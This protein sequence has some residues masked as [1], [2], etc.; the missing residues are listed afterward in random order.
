MA[1]VVHK[2]AFGTS[3][4]ETVPAGA[5][6]VQIEVYGAGG[7]GGASA[8]NSA[9]GGGGGGYTTKT[10]G[11]T[12][13]DTLTYTIGFG[14]GGETAPNNGAVGTTVTVTGTVSG[15]SVSLTANSG[16]GGFSSGAG[17]SG[18]T[19]S[20]GTTNN[21]GGSG[22]AAGAGGTGA[23]PLA[24][25]G[26]VAGPAGNVGTVPGGGGGGSGVGSSGAGASGE[27]IFTYSTIFADFM[28]ESFQT[29]VENTTFLRKSVQFL[30]ATF[31]ILSAPQPAGVVINPPIASVAMA[32]IVP[33]TQNT[34]NPMSWT[35]A[36][37]YVQTDAPVRNNWIARSWM[38][39]AQSNIGTVINVP[40]T[41]V[42]LHANTAGTYS[43]SMWVW[44][45]S[46]DGW[47]P[48]EVITWKANASYNFDLLAAPN[49]VASGGAVTIS[50]PFGS[51]ATGT[52]QPIINTG[53]PSFVIPVAQVTLTPILPYLQTPLITQPLAITISVYPP[54]IYT[55][56]PG[57]RV[58]AVTA[59]YYNGVFYNAGDVF[60]ILK[61]G[62]FSD[63]TVNYEMGGGIWA[64]GW[65]TQV[66]LTTPLYNAEIQA[67]YPFYPF[68]DPNRR[69]VL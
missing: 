20:G 63:S 32:A 37:V 39:I 24:S 23:A 3:L 33:Q 41:S 9:L 29:Y 61:A 54:T 45:P 6:Q 21:T 53:N 2:Y 16:S 14:G 43:S 51:I 62:D 8:N 4:T 59:G 12:A 69:F 60:D 30:A 49:T 10:I 46:D 7:S 68:V 36:P 34:T 55:Q 57:F 56:P 35:S 64:V 27:V 67:F 11:C 31:L 22:I 26:G 28:T 52:F 1:T 58:Q 17:G 25:P 47:W 66:P 19:G 42:T 38:L 65:M 40:L 44:L 50:V 13:G 5:F 15:G 18:G 48:E